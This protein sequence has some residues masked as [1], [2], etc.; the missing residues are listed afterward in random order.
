MATLLIAEHDN[1]AGQGRHP[2]GADRRQGAGQARAC[3]GRRARAPA[4]AADHAAKLDGVE[5]VLL[6]EAPIYG[7]IW[8]SR[9][10]R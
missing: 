7:H 2:Q 3:A 10:L 6:A 9:W 5:K 1:A 8:P 4:A